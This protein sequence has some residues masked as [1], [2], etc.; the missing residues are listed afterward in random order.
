MQERLTKEFLETRD[1]IEG[2]I[3]KGD[4]R[5]TTEEAASMN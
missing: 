1:L 3:F 5:F 2:P 4:Q